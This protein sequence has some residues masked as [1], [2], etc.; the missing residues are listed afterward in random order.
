MLL[1]FSYLGARRPSRA[2]K[3]PRGALPAWSF[4]AARCTL[5][6]RSQGRVMSH[7]WLTMGTSHKLLASSGPPTEQCWLSVAAIDSDTFP[8]WS[9]EAR[10]PTRYHRRFWLLRLGFCLPSINITDGFFLPQSPYSVLAEAL[11]HFP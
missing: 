5:L 6:V 4:D 8:G 7:D 9:L 3:A 11:C 2:A 10:Q 1:L